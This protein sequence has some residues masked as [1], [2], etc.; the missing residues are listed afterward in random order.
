[1][2]TSCFLID[3][4]FRSMIFDILLTHNF[5]LSPIPIYTKVLGLG[6]GFKNQ[7]IMERGVLGFGNDE[8]ELF[9]YQSGAD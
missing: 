6:G 7:E 9:L 4:K 3:M 2:S 8:M 1:M 5:H